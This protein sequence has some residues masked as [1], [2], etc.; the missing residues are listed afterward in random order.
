[1]AKFFIITEADLNRKPPVTAPTEL[2]AA[3]EYTRNENIADGRIIVI[4][5]DT[6]STYR[7]TATT[8][9]TVVKE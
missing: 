1:M 7:V 4:P 3:Q 6:A 5:E 2:E 9:V 8:D